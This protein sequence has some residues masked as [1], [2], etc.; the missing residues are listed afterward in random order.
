MK[1][2]KCISLALTGIL[3][4]GI[5]GCSQDNVDTVQEEPVKENL[6]FV[7]ESTEAIVKSD[8]VGNY[9]LKEIAPI[10]KDGNT[11]GWITMNQAEKL[12]IFDWT[13]SA[14]VDSGVKFSYTF[15]FKM[16]FLPQLSNGDMKTFYFNPKLVKKDKVIGNPCIVGWSGFAGTAVF[17]STTQTQYVEYGVQPLRKSLKGSKLILDISD[18]DGNNYDPIIYDYSVL[19]KAID[20]PSIITSG[21]K[22]VTGA[23]GAKYKV[24]LDNVCVENCFSEYQVLKNDDYEDIPRT[25]ALMFDYKIDYLNKPTSSLQVSNID[26]TKKGAAL[27]STD[28][29]IKVQSDVEKKYYTEADYGLA[30]WKYSNGLKLEYCSTSLRYKIHPGTYA[31]FTCN[32][33]LS[34]V[35]YSGARYYRFVVEFNSEALAMSPEKLMKFNGRFMVF[36]KPLAAR[37]VYPQK[38]HKHAAIIKT[39]DDNALKI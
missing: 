32:R 22:T 25:K 13:S 24:T 30:R 14:A 8:N 39:N 33:P 9:K 12:G 6:S 27:L 3:C 19:S 34:D 28:L 17:D 20:G 4:I 35:T 26:R 23:S 38:T 10:M 29:N 11:Y 21:G 31:Q 37:V 1:M 36:Q 16:D 18:S 15:N 5:I 7:E 2:K